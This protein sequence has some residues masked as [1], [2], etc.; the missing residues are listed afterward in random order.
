MGAA[1]GVWLYKEESGLCVFKWAGIYDLEA[2]ELEFMAILYRSWIHQVNPTKSDIATS[3]H[4]YH[5][6]VDRITYDARFNESWI[7][8]SNQGWRRYYHVGF[9]FDLANTFNGR[10]GAAGLQQILWQELFAF[11]EFRRKIYY[12]HRKQNNFRP[13]IAQAYLPC[14]NC[15]Q[16]PFFPQSILNNNQQS[17]SYGSVDSG[18][19]H[20]T[21]TQSTHSKVYKMLL[22]MMEGGHLTGTQYRRLIGKK[23]M[24]EAFL[25]LYILDNS[26]PLSRRAMDVID[27][28][29]DGANTSRRP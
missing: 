24:L 3:T 18:S 4:Q 6:H 2:E 10:I 1:T 17:T 22:E 15:L 20:Q 9:W 27:E 25:P 11:M 29:Y 21:Q 19:G 16:I 23:E 13:L 8:W 7:N 14:P 12:S 5:D 28:F 26:V